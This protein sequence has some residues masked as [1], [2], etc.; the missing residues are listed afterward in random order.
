MLAG[1]SARAYEKCSFF[2]IFNRLGTLPQV[3]GQVKEWLTLKLHEM[4]KVL[5]VVVRP[6]AFFVLRSTLVGGS[7]I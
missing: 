4:I 1:R 7:I 2:S 6:I 3:F 5:H